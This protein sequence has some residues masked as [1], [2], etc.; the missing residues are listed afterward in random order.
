MPAI[1]QPLRRVG[2][3]K[4]GPNHGDTTLTALVLEL[5]TLRRDRECCIRMAARL[6][7]MERAIE[8]EMEEVKKHEH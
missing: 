2:V 6:R 4:G 8:K 3:V 5:Q 1:L 7:T